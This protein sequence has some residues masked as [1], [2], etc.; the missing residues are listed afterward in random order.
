MPKEKSPEAWGLM[1]ATM[2]GDGKL[3]LFVTNY[4]FEIPV[5]Y[6]NLG[7]GLF[8]D[9]SRKAKNSQPR[10]FPHVQLGYMLRRF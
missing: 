7:A 5:L 6:R 3:D 4:Q 2:T 1:Q 10:F 9:A 8:E